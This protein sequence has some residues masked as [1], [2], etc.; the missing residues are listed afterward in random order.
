LPYVCRALPF[1]RA[2]KEPP[3]RGQETG[4]WGGR[5]EFYCFG[6]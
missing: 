4:A 1:F 2:K 3:L 6:P 5:K